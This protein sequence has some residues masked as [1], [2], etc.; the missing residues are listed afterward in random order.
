MIVNMWWE[1]N[2]YRIIPVEK[3]MS[4]FRNERQGQCWL[5]VANM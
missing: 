2:P 4:R 3:D 1:V 5:N